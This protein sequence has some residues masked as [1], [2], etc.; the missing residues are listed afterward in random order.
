MIAAPR[1]GNPSPTKTVVKSYWKLESLGQ[2]PVCMCFLFLRTKSAFLKKCN[3]LSVPHK[4]KE[5]ALASLL[6]TRAVHTKRFLLEQ[7]M[8]EECFKC[9]RPSHFQQRFSYSTYFLLWSFLFRDWFKNTVPPSG[10]EGL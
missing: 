10:A 7:F 2:I 9:M 1:A 8:R 3:S 5:C 4:Q 6:S